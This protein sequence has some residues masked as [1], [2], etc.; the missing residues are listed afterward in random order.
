MSKTAV[1]IYNLG[2]PDS[3]EAVR[4]FLHNLF[5]DP[6]ILRVPSLLRV[7][8]AWFIA[9]RRTAAARQIYQQI[10]GRSP[11]LPETNKQAVALQSLLGESYRVFI[12]MRYWHPLV[13][14]VVSSIKDWGPDQVVL[15]PLYPQF[16]TTTTGS[17]MRVWQSASKKAGLFLP[18]AQACC[19]PE[20]EGF[21]D[22]IARLTDQAIATVPDNT[23]CR[24][25]FSAHGLPERF[26]VS[27]DPYAAQVK[28]TVAS[29]CAR[30]KNPSVDHVV[31][32]QSRVGPLE[33]LRPYTED[34][35][36]RAGEEGVS[37]VLVPVAFVSEHSET[38]VELDIEYR[39]LARKAGVFK[40]L[41]VPTVN[42]DNKFIESLAAM[43][44]SMP[45]TGIVPGGSTCNGG[46]VACPCANT[47]A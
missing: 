11:I 35:I 5:S 12:A 39:E 9:W 13:D 36:R 6:Q 46:F 8:L 2:G 7:A 10:G 43:V 47:A 3:L 22:A 32:Y 40:Y 37:V 45:K 41:R 38:L 29:V 15:V 20:A 42:T 44:R 4:P 17:F 21:V 14:S 31:C 30:L 27:G 1:V 24:I 19:W 33:W 16:S 28:R 34:E 26:I 25:L 23:P 18:T